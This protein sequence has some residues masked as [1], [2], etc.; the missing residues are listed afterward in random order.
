MELLENYTVYRDVLESRQIGRAFQLVKPKHEDQASVRNDNSLCNNN[1]TNILTHLG[2]VACM[3]Y[4][5]KPSAF[6]GGTPG[7]T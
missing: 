1:S 4:H 3:A 2:R 5:E 6:L 7:V